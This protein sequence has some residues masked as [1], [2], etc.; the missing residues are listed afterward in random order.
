M[1][2]RFCVLPLG[3]WRSTLSQ[4]WRVLGRWWTRHSYSYYYGKPCVLSILL[5]FELFVVYCWS[6]TV[7]EWVYY[8]KS[9]V[10]HCPSFFAWYWD[11]S[12]L[13]YAAV[14]QLSSSDVHDVKVGM[15]FLFQLMGDTCT[16]GCRFCSVKTAKNPPPLDPEEPYNTAKAIAEWGLDYVVLT[17]VDR[18][19]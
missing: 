14:S 1:Q 2:V 3:M 17:S 4:H 18:D 9:R 16:R 13:A 19:G 6:S 5:T 10:K 7:V 11:W 12:G 8:K 15:S